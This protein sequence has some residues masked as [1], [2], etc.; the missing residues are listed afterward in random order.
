MLN[1]H[2]IYLLSVCSNLLP[3]FKK[4]TMFC[5]FFI[6]SRYEIIYMSHRYFLP[7]C[8]CLSIAMSFEGQTF[9]ILIKSNL[10]IYLF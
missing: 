1:C 5:K 3:I 4:L 9:L 2:T 7:V 6:H 10:S 8:D